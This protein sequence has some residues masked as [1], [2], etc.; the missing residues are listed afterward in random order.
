MALVLPPT[1]LAYEATAIQAALCACLAY[2]N[3]LLT[4]L[5]DY[6]DFSTF[7]AT[8]QILDPGIGVTG[9]AT[10]AAKEL[11]ATRG[12]PDMRYLYPIFP[13][14]GR[15]RPAVRA[16]PAAVARHADVARRAR[17]VHGPWV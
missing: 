7:E 14:R 11:G 8:A 6:L 1:Q 10:P 16:Q 3:R 2:W 9:V 5:G 13:V 15:A 17:G 12:R 4:G